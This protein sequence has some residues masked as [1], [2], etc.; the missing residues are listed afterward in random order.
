MKTIIAA[1]LALSFAGP[2]LAF[3]AEQPRLEKTCFCSKG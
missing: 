2:S 1:L 3:K